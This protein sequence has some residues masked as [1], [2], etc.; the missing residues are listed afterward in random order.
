MGSKWRLN[1]LQYL[2]LYRKI[3]DV[4]GFISLFKFRLVNFRTT[5]NLQEREYQRL[6]EKRKDAER[7]SIDISIKKG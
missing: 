4:A 3:N 5:L 7:F 6:K 2:R 1:E